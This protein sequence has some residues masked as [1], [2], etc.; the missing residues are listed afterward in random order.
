MGDRSLDAAVALLED[1]ADR[2]PGRMELST[3]ALGA[4]P[5]AVDIVF[6][7]T[8]DH[9]MLEKRYRGERVVA[10]VIHGPGRMNPERVST[11][12]VERQNLTMRMSIRRFARRTN[13]FS[14]NV[15]NHAHAVALHYMHYNFC[16]THETLRVTPVMEAGVTDHFW[17]VPDLVRVI[18]NATPAP[19]PRG[20][21]RRR[22]SSN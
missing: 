12:L 1:L 8:V 4:Y 19:G 21:Y 10:H 3:D 15:E 7:P 5:E 17:D 11:S 20:P 18:D 13:A 16:R 2:V 14:R 6:G 22:E 9:A